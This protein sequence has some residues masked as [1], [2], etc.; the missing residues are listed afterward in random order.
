MSEHPKLS[1]GDRLKS[2]SLIFASVLLRTPFFLTMLNLPYLPASCGTAL[3]SDGYANGVLGSGESPLTS[4]PSPLTHPSFP[5]N[6]R[7]HLRERTTA[8]DTDTW[9]VLK[10]V[11][12]ADALSSHNYSRTVNSLI[13]AGT[14]VGMVLFGTFPLSLLSDLH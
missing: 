9:T 11:Y 7:M 2:V 12:G 1:F 14:I 4:S 6:T 8:N 5:V 13:F 3:F 10:R